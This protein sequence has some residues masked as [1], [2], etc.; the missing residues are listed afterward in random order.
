[1][2]AAILDMGH[3]DVL[4]SFALHSISLAEL[5]VLHHLNLS[6]FASVVSLFSSPSSSPFAYARI[7]K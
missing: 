3:V 5:I 7:K 6:L 2:V 1:M 4:E